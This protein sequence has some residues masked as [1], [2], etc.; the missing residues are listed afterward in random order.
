MKIITLS[1]GSETIV[2]NEDYDY[3]S[4]FRWQPSG[5]A[6][7]R[8]TRENKTSGMHRE[9]AMLVGLFSVL[10][11]HKDRNWRNNLRENLRAASY[12][13]NAMNRGPQ[14]GGMYSSY[15]GVSFLQKNKKWTSRIKKKGLSLFIGY[16]E[17]EDEAALA[18]NAQA[19]K[20]FGE[21]AYFNVI[22]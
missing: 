1:D 12:S 4:Q 9:I 2:S 11:D 6:V 19:M 21:F 22:E 14:R 7:I 13:Q 10:I 8:T 17:K 3:L 16:F 20:L 5:S 18:Y 15:K